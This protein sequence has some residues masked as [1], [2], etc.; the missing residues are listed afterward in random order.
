MATVGVK[1]FIQANILVTFN[2]FVGHV[3]SESSFIIIYITAK[4]TIPQRHSDTSA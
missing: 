1:G 2:S 3:E 4:H